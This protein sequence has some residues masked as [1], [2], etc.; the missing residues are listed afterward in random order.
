[1]QHEI[2]AMWEWL[3]S[4]GTRL[5]PIGMLGPLPGKSTAVELDWSIQAEGAAE[6]Y[7]QSAAFVIAYQSPVEPRT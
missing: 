2:K 3:S 5:L 7:H 1:M 4:T 6:W